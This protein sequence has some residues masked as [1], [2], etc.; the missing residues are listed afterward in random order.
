MLRCSQGRHLANVARS[1]A[2]RQLIANDVHRS[3][4]ST[5]NKITIEHEEL[6]PENAGADVVLVMGFVGRSGTLA[7]GTSRTRNQ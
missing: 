5:I 7:S 4:S 2:T 6:G 3:I 1:Q